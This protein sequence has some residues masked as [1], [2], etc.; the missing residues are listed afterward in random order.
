MLHAEFG[1]PQ[2]PKPPPPHVSGAVHVPQSIVPPQPSDTVPHWPGWQAVAGTHTHWLSA[3]QAL[4]G[5][6]MPQLI[7]PP[8]PLGAVPHCWPLGQ[9]VCG[10]HTQ[11]VP[12]LLQTWPA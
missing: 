2:R 4:P 9:V 5:G 10:A 3:V 6:Q 12:P 7:V 8:Q 1:T 11:A